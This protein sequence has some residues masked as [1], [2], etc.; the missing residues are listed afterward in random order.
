MGLGALLT[1]EFHEL[2]HEWQAL[3]GKCGQGNY[4]NRQFR[5]KAG[6]YGL[7]VDARGHTWVEPGRFT[8]LLIEHG[9]DLESIP[10]V[11]EVM[12]RLRGK[13]QAAEIFLRLHQCAMCR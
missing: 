7:V 1:T 4:H 13:Q 12:P 6:L 11:E 3:Y 10:A 5:Q 8:A 2:L 9:V